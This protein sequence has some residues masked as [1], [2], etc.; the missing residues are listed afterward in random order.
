MGDNTTTLA[1]IFILVV[2]GVVVALAVVSIEPSKTVSVFTSLNE[3]KSGPSVKLGINL[4][5]SNFWTAI[6]NFETVLPTI[7]SNWNL[8]S[9]ALPWNNAYFTNMIEL[10]NAAGDTQPMLAWTSLAF[11]LPCI[12]YGP[13]GSTSLE[14]GI[15]RDHTGTID[16]LMNGIATDVFQLTTTGI[17]NKQG[18]QSIIG[19]ALANGAAVTTINLPVSEPDT[20]YAVVCTPNGSTALGAFWVDTK[21]VGSFHFHTTNNAGAAST[22]DCIITH[23]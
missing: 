21:A 16:F 6:Q 13:G 9:S 7:A 17:G 1:L 8:G 19:Q 2:V 3:T 15:C 23:Q 14:S 20:S 22:V 10:L 5:N 11:H 12:E 4:A 18:F